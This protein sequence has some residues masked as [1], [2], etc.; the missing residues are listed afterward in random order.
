[1]KQQ[2]T[3]IFVDQL[4]TLNQLPSIVDA[5]SA[6]PPNLPAHKAPFHAL[7]TPIPAYSGDARYKR[8]ASWLA[9]NDA[10]N[11]L[12]CFETQL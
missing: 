9:C 12:M 5:G 4:L 7:R 3:N 1:M 10:H 2:L 6:N 11:A 8:F